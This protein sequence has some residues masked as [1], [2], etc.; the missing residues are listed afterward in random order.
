LEEGVLKIVT[1]AEWLHGDGVAG[2]AGDI[3]TGFV[4]GVGKEGAG[5]GDVFF[6]MSFVE[7]VFGLVSLLGNG[8]HAD[9]MNGRSSRA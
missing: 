3:P 7:L 9:A 8:E 1:S 4:I 5:A 2:V 6:G